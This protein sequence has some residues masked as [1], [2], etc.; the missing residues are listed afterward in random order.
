MTG[1]VIIK[2]MNFIIEKTQTFLKGFIP[3]RIPNTIVL[4][5]LHIEAK[6]ESIGKRTPLI[7]P[8]PQ[9]LPVTFPTLF[10][11][12]HTALILPAASVSVE[13]HKKHNMDILLN[14]SPGK[15]GTI[16]QI[17]KAGEY[18][19]NQSDWGNVRFGRSDM[20]YSG[21]EILATCN[22]LTALGETVSAQ[23]VA[24]MIAMYEC[25]GA[26][27]GG[28]FGTSPYALEEYFRQQGYRVETTTSTDTAQINAIGAGSDT[29]IVNA[30]NNKNDIMAMIHTVSITRDKKE[31]F[32]VH[33]AYY[34]DQTN[35]FAAKGSY[36]SLQEAV[37]AISNR[38]P[39]SIV[40]IGISKYG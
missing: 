22:A 17:Y 20:A 31:K 14:G 9:A 39:E 5:V 26:V 18:I 23:T 37:H 28:R 36:G 4:S 11:I 7:L 8:F 29:V 3:H 25:Y 30:Y 40:V 33:N 21:C 27:L 2:T 10:P 35:Q 1:A 15:N 19:E 34:R 38:N 12:S 16:K 24:D 6:M 13:N 32:S